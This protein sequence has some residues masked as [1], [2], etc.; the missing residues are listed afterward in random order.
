MCSP[1]QRKS[2]MASL[3]RLITGRAKADVDRREE[4]N[5]AE[6]EKALEGIRN[7]ATEIVV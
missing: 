7:G 2:T 5:V 6:L 1:R 3:F 4:N